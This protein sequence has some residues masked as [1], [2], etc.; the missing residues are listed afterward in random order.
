MSS[1]S[2]IG[3]SAF[4]SRVLRRLLAIMLPA[5]SLMGGVILALYYQDL[6]NEHALH[7]QASLYRVD[8]QAD[9]LHR[10]LKSVESDLYYL[11]QQRILQD[12]LVDNGVSKR[13]LEEEYVLFCRQRGAYDQIRYLDATGVERIRINYNKGRPYVVP[14][15]E[16][17]VKGG[18]YYFMQTMLLGPGEVFISPFD[19]NVEHDGIERPLKSVIRCAMPVF[20]QR[21]VK[22]GILALNFLG[23]A[24]LDKLAEATAGFSGDI[25]LLNRQGF[26]LRGPS[27]DDEWGFML[28]HDRTFAT[29]F[30][31]E[32][33]LISD[34]GKGQFQTPKG[35]FTFRTFSPRAELPVQRQPKV[36]SD[37][38]SDPDVGDADLVL[39]AYVPSPVLDGQANAFLRR[40]LWFCGGILI[41]V[42]V[43][44]WY[45]AYTASLRRDHERN[46]AD[47][48]SR[49]RLLSTQL[50]TAQEDERR[51]ISRDLHDELGQ[52]VT[53][54]VLD[55]Q[56]GAGAGDLGRK[57]EQINRA[58]HSSSCLLDRIHEISMRLR[59]TLLDDLGLK[60]AVQNLL[61]DFEHRTG[62][63]TTARLHFEQTALAPAIS[64]NIYR[65]LQEALTNVSKHA[66]PAEVLVSLH[67]EDDRAVL[68]VR[69][70]GVGVESAALDSKRLGLLGMRERAELLDGSF[71]L[72]SEAS[73]GT[74][75]KVTIPLGKVP[76]VGEERPPCS[77]KG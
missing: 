41:L 3:P 39:V 5:V 55:L 76:E 77:T 49:L 52:I 23:D 7:E 75:I 63:T 53:S 2:A 11:S 15:R 45:L 8:L 48:A 19:L 58:L 30:P 42:L 62:I 6:R 60:D 31:K 56:R 32:W 66:Q 47:S 44:V 59:P 34:F 18:R 28:G 35:L 38:S 54:I 17:Q 51:R 36:L 71:V 69:D 65:I 1:Y 29:Y 24:L 73:G 70:N 20:D 40:L 43:L 12:L 16:L 67:L 10:E 57:N 9:I 72:K 46:L 33:S 22:R 37:T 14:E 4:S 13:E 64:E 50:L 26:F 25:W 27:P 68:T 74:E 61:S 21:N